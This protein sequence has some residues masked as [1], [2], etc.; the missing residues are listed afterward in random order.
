MAFS[1]SD[2]V[3]GAETIAPSDFS[4]PEDGTYEF[5]L[6][7]IY[8]KE[9]SQA[10]PDA[11]WIFVEYQLETG[12]KYNELF[13]LPKD[14]ERPTENERKTIGRY[15]SRLQSLGVPRNEVNTVNTDT[16]VGRTGALTLRTTTNRQSGREYQNISKLVVNEPSAALDAHFGGNPAQQV[17]GVRATPT[18]SAVNPFS[19]Q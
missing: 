13:T 19:G 14:P 10:N 15:L 5:E 2:Y 16:L 8:V 12:T 18:S 17:P 6:T 11:R 7:D 9:G 3:T 4:G 1:L